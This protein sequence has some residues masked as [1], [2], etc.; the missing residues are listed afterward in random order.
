MR[1]WKSSALIVV[2]AAAALSQTASQLQSDAV[3]RVGA[4]LACLCGA[5]KNT[6]ADCP[7]LE[8]HFAKPA[9]VR[10][11]ALQAQGKSDS[12]IIALFVAE[13]GKQVLAVPPAEGFNLLAWTMPFVAIAAGLALVWHF[14]QRFRKP[15]SVAAGQE[16][17]LLRYREEIE[18]DLARL[19]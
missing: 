12:E 1:R 7:M 10:I 19:D 4:H 8:C 9:R 17:T 6:V 16:D 15:P 13:H 2:L 5:C 18:K 3:R 11:A 14:I